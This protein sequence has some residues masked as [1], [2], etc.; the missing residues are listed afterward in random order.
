MAMREGALAPGTTWKLVRIFDEDTSARTVAGGELGGCGGEVENLWI[1]GTRMVGR[2]VAYAHCAVTTAAVTP[3]HPFSYP[4]P[5]SINSL[6]MQSTHIRLIIARLGRRHKHAQS[7]DVAPRQV[8]EQYEYTAPALTTTVALLRE[9]GDIAVGLPYMKGAAGSLL[10]IIEIKDQINVCRE[11]CRE[12]L[13]DVDRATSLVLNMHTKNKGLDVFPPEI[14]RVLDNL[15]QNL[16]DV[17]IVLSR[18]HRTSSWGK[19]QLIFERS[20]LLK[21][22]ETS[23]RR[24]HNTIEISKTFLI[25]NDPILHN[26]KAQ[27]S[28]SPIFISATSSRPQIFYGRTTSVDS[29]LGTIL[30]QSAI[31]ARIAILGPGG[32]GKTAFALEIL[33]NEKLIERFQDYRYFIA[34]NTCTT[35]EL[36]LLKIAAALNIVQT[37]CNL[38]TN[39]LMYFQNNHE[40]KSKFGIIFRGSCPYPFSYSAHYHEGDRTAKKTQKVFHA[41]AD[42]WDLWAEK[43]IWEDK[44]LLLIERHQN[45]HLTSIEMSIQLSIEYSTR[46]YPSTI[47]I[48]TIISKLPGGL[49]LDKIDIYNIIFPDIADIYDGVKYLQQHSLAFCT[50]SKMLQTHQ[51]IRYYCL[52][53]FELTIDQEKALNNYYIDLALTG[54]SKQSLAPYLLQEEENITAILVKCLNQVDVPPIVI[55]AALQFSNFCI[56]KGISSDQLLGCIYAHKGELIPSLRQLLF[57]TWGHYLFCKEQFAEAKES[58]QQLLFL[59]K[60]FLDPKHEAEALEHLAQIAYT[61]GQHDESISLHQE[62][63]TI[64]ENIDDKDGQAIIFECLSRM[65]IF[66]KDL[67]SGREYAYKSL[68]L[69]QHTGNKSGQGNSWLRLGDILL[70]ESSYTKAEECYT[71]AGQCFVANSDILGHATSLEYMGDINAAQK[72]LD[73]AEFYYLKA[74]QIYKSL[75]SSSILGNVLLALGKL[76]YGQ[77]YYDKSIQY[78]TEALHIYLKDNNSLKQGSALRGLGSVYEAQGHYNDAISTF[79]MAQQ[80]HSAIKASAAAAS[81]SNHLAYLYH[82][83]GEFQ[84]AEQCWLEAL[85]L[86]HN[87]NS[88]GELCVDRHQYD[89]AIKYYQNVIDMADS[90]HTFL[91]K[92]I[93]L[94]GLGHVYDCQGVFEHS[95]EVLRE[96]LNEFQKLKHI[97]GQLSVLNKLQVLY[98]KTNDLVK[99]DQCNKLTFDIS[100]VKLLY[101]IEAEKDTSDYMQLVNLIEDGES[102]KIKI[103]IGQ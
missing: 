87:A 8:A 56:N 4:V 47:L 14:L 31:S 95:I 29:V 90:G 38:K 36:L 45:H 84:L 19:F 40:S 24:L 60:E 74:L 22:L 73:A 6:Q 65:C 75:D 62:A 55:E 53:H 92:G 59:A 1:A 39:I 49:H 94:E 68:S 25:L 16:K 2:K 64:Y 41:I 52:E 46:L 5:Q 86:H 7:Q 98:T 102:R 10:R 77:Q 81:D 57:S 66:Q 88:L 54:I 89:E 21:L 79:K 37:N 99:A 69:F 44:G 27:R 42:K 3:S 33:H 26:V 50:A 80:L 67:S 58:Y 17:N 9:I 11:R 28:A 72:K 78:Y 100:H 93:A 70:Q 20:E 82:S 61:M 35:L 48:L 63:L 96:A 15:S 85:E 34:C 76:Y 83:L 32:I 43:I 71:N 12:I 103:V 30:Q 97:E 91:S 101:G 23:G 13:E 51:L 18:C